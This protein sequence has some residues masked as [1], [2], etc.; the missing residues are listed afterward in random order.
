M[1]STIK[2]I[3]TSVSVLIALV[4]IGTSSF[5]V[6]GGD[7]YTISLNG[8]VLVSQSVYDPFDLKTLPLAEANIN[9][10]LVITYMQCNAP[11]KVGKNRTISVKDESGK[12]VKEWR[13]K[14]SDGSDKTMIIPVKEILALQ[15]NSSGSLSF[16]YHADGLQKPQKMALVQGKKKNNG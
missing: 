3:A 10:N 7:G 8:K 16:I 4:F 11:G 2:S 6:K 13:F 9:D 14:D 15:K 1:K 12:L 5:N